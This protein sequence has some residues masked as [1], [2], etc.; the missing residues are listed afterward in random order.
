MQAPIRVGSSCLLPLK[1]LKYGAK[2]RPV[3]IRALNSEPAFEKVYD[4]FFG[5]LPLL[6]GS[7]DN[8][9]D[10]LFLAIGLATL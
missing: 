8:H 7:D 5:K 4:I 6:C 2:C 9:T 10:R 3:T 1:T